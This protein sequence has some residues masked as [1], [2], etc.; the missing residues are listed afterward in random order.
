MRSN[1]FAL[2]A[3]LLL[4]T[5]LAGCGTQSA[6]PPDDATAN[7]ARSQVERGPVRVTAEVQPVRPRLSDS[8]TLTLTL[9]YEE[10]VTVEKPLF[11]V[12]IGKFTIRDLREPLP[13]TDNGRVILQ[14]IYTLEPTEAGRLRIDPIAVTFADRRPQGDNAEH[15][16]ETESLSIEVSS[17]LGDKTPTLGDLHPPAAPIT[18]PSG[19]SAW[20]WAIGVLALIA[21]AAMAWRRR[22]RP[23]AKAGALKMNILTSEDL[24]NMELDKL[25][26][27]GL[28]TSDIKQFYI[29]LTAIVRRYIERTTGIRAPEQTTEEFLREISRTQTFEL[30]VRARLRDFLETADLVKFATHRPTS[31]DVDESVR[32]ARLFIGTKKPAPPSDLES[33]SGE[34][35]KGRLFVGT[36]EPAPPTALESKP[37]EDLEATQP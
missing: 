25:I 20:L 15:S 12:S 1:N 32:R 6:T 36:K 37:G 14:Q 24:A 27:S 35:L 11:G 2:L 4:L 7:H 18:L 34:D 22:R 33:G 8:P 23:H 16:I 30:D 21:V 3:W 28:A 29:E 19:S 9:D 5:T 13:K 26:A 10:G 31:E 17:L